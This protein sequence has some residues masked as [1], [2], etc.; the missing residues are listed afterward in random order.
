MLAPIV[1]RPNNFEIS[2]QLPL[3]CGDDNVDFG[4]W[5]SNVGAICD[6]YGVGEEMRKVIAVSRLDG[7]AKKFYYS[8]TNY[9]LL[10][11]DEFVQ[12][13]RKMFRVRIDPVQ[14]MMKLQNK[15]WR[16]GECYRDYHFEKV[17]LANKLGI[18]N[19]LVIGYLIDGIEN[20]TI[21]VQ[22]SGQS[23][24]NPC[25]M[26][27]YM[28][29]LSSVVSKPSNS[30]K[31]NDASKKSVNPS[32]SSSK[33]KSQTENKPTTKCYNCGEAGHVS[34]D[35]KKPKNE[36]PV[37]YKCKKPGH[38]SRNC[39]TVEKE[40]TG[41]LE[42]SEPTMLINASTFSKPNYLD[43]SVKREDGSLSNFVV[44]VDTGSPIN[45]VKESNVSKGCEI[46]PV[47][48]CSF[49]GINCSK[50]RIIGVIARQ[51]KV[52]ERWFW[53]KFYVVPNDTMS[54]RCLVG[55]EFLNDSQLRFIFQNNEIF[56]EE[57]SVDEN[58]Y[59][60]SEVHSLM[61]IEVEINNDKEVVINPNVDQKWK[62]KLLS[63]YVEHYKQP[64]TEVIMNGTTDESY[65]V[66][67]HLKDDK[68]F[69]FNPRRLS[70][71]EKDAVQSILKDW[72]EKGVIKPSSSEYTSPIV[73]VK[74][75][76][77]EFRLCVDYRVLNSKVV[78]NHY[79]IPHIDDHLD[80]M[81]SK[82]V[83]SKLDLK[84]G[85]LNLHVHSDSRKYT[86]FITPFGQYEFCRMPFGF[87][88]AP[89]EFQAF[90]NRKFEKLIA[91]GKV[92]IYIDDILVATETVEENLEILKE[93]FDILAKNCLELR[94]DKCSF[95]DDS[96][97][98]LGYEIDRYGLKPSKD[99][100]EAV[101]NFPVPRNI[102]DVK[103]FLG[104][105]S[106][107]RRFIKDFAVHAKPLYDLL[108][109]EVSF[110]F[111]VEELDTFQ[112]LINKLCSR[113]LLSIYSPKAETQLHCD[114]S[115]T[116]F[117]SILFQR[118]KDSSLHP[119]SFYSKR[120]TEAES[121]FHSYELEMLAIVNS[122][123]RFRVYLQNI[124]FKIITDCNAVKFA[125]SKKDLMPK[126][127]RWILE[128]QS[129]DF[130]IE[131]RPGSRMQ[132][133]DALSRSTNIMLIENDL[134]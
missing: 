9:P 21:R 67:I 16:I 127:S 103:R 57:E 110:Q 120:T 76:N 87:T 101:K 113:P 104:L 65:S 89:A 8:I 133:V 44:L 30:N 93:V 116:G 3:F 6:L 126:V 66:K 105:M 12:S 80:S 114:A 123:K 132:H 92:V 121:R 125:F 31:S 91:D 88:N 1:N 73:L 71:A 115:S 29:K 34:V 77:G 98:Y 72:L 14:L 52:K 83:F 53:T 129:Y 46:K 97:V 19:N 60:N 107:F 37:C 33:P 70:W 4:R 22:A 36:K 51:V 18:A 64:F 45:L 61:S 69:S 39:T 43:V 56:V 94:L 85:F 10:S 90:V 58:P 75:K 84:S 119:I 124:R 95:L 55:R 32:S 100:V 99:H 11:W 23:F 112:S 74:K 27:D 78:R 62:D 13:M 86:S 79:P 40:L 48:N 50:L 130:E 15:K 5:I 128:M 25:D 108:R 49:S 38:I 28:Q 102:H 20:F 122:I 117:G 24:A 47:S 63:L 82:K 7:M 54:F 26:L 109:K 68:P 2:N 118:Q 106:Y 42:E 81:G 134:D 111:G 41:V 59:V 35:C 96:V 17:M 131:H